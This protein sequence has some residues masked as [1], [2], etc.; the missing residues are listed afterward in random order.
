MRNCNK[1]SLLQ[2]VVVAVYT[3]LTLF[4]CKTARTANCTD[5][6]YKKHQAGMNTDLPFKNISEALKF[7]VLSAERNNVLSVTLI[8]KVRFRFLTM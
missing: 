2:F 5:C 3:F 1:L 6:N 4:S 7:H 8:H